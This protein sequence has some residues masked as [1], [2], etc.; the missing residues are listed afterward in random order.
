MKNKITYIA[1]T[2]AGSM[3]LETESPH[4]YGCVEK[5]EAA[6]AN[7]PYKNWEALKRRGYTIDKYNSVYEEDNND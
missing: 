6:T 5:L 4:F 2:P 3:V 7:M 1:S